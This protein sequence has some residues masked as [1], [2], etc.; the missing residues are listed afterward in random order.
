MK[1]FYL[2]KVNTEK[3]GKIRKQ[4][5]INTGRRSKKRNVSVST[6]SSVSL[7]FMTT[8][9]LSQETY[10]TN[11]HSTTAVEHKPFLKEEL[12]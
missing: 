8:Q 12:T 9:Q 2:A 4:V 11:K 1:L 3:K 7:K 6:P 10:G 5:R